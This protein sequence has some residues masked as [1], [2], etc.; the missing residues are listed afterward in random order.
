MWK[1]IVCR[2]A[3]LA[4]AD[5]FCVFVRVFVTS[6][7][8]AT[9]TT[10]KYITFVLLGVT[11]CAVL[12]FFIFLHIQQSKFESIESLV[13]WTHTYR[14][15]YRQ[16]SVSCMVSVSGIV[17]AKKSQMIFLYIYIIYPSMICLWLQNRRWVHQGIVNY[18]RYGYTICIVYD[19]TINKIS[20]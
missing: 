6:S 3:A 13:I 2:R 5:E 11:S 14:Y 10:L 18:W 12:F 15:R 19:L 9:E 4:R 7:R 1:I 20:Y 16:V 8:L 17:F